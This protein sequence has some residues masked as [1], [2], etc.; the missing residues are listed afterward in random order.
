METPEKSLSTETRI[1][2][3]HDAAISANPWQVFLK[4][5]NISPFKQFSI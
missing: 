5:N 1:M 2:G 4:P 3:G